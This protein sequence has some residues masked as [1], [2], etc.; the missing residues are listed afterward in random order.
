MGAAA[1]SRGRKGKHPHR[2]RP[3]VQRQ[4]G[5]ARR[6]AGFS[7]Q[8]QPGLAWLGTRSARS[9]RRQ[10]TRSSGGQWPG[11]AWPG[12]GR[13]WPSGNG[14]GGYAAPG[15]Y[16]AQSGY[17]GDPRNDE[18]LAGEANGVGRRPAPPRREDL[19]ARNTQ[20]T[21]DAYPPGADS[22]DL[23]EDYGRPEYVPF[24]NRETQPRFGRFGAVSA[25]LPGA[26][27]YPAN[28]FPPNGAPANGTPANGTPPNDRSPVRDA[29]P[30]PPYPADEG[31]PPQELPMD[32][33]KAAHDEAPREPA[34]KGR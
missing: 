21:Q 32:G 10:R 15:E 12:N 22:P 14:T 29:E 30:Y 16:A 25:P 26:H 1:A 4:P 5:G 8:R 6:V 9:S 28:G 17:L 27:D 11:P 23:A 31:P 7:L 33:E 24:D 20:E 2:S 3:E 34:L 18:G 19:W 13:A